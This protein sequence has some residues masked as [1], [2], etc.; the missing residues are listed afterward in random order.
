MREQF[1][2]PSPTP[3][4]RPPMLFNQAYCILGFENTPRHAFSWVVFFVWYFLLLFLFVCLFVCLF[5][6][7]LFVC[8]FFVFCWV[9]YLFVSAKIEGGFYI[10]CDTRFFHKYIL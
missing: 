6:F 1:P 4:S 7:V 2:L 8:L 3:V 5:C 10:T 9:V